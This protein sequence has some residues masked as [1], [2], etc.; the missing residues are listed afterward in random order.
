MLASAEAVQPNRR[1]GSFRGMKSP[2]GRLRR[3][4]QRASVRRRIAAF[5]GVSFV[6]SMLL[7]LFAW[8]TACSGTACPA[9]SRLNE[10]D[11]VQASKVFAADGRRIFDYGTE[12]R[13]VKTLK[14]MS[15]SIPAAFLAVEDKRFYEH[16]G[17]DWV[18]FFGAIKNNILAGGMAEGFSTITMQLA[19]NL[20]PEEIDRRRRGIRGIPR[21][22]REARFATEIERRYSKERILE[23][24]LN[25]ISLGSRAFGV[26]EA[27][28][29]YFGKSSERLNVAEAAMLAALPKAPERYNPR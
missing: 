17:V 12:R 2:S 4:W 10:F 8:Y 26:E 20:F 7:I 13:T 23:L 27:S 28:Q 22:I 14:E 29:R 24:Y 15:P 18:R 16:H 21:K 11:P 19:G 1:V 9:I 25:Q 6:A 5:L 3:W